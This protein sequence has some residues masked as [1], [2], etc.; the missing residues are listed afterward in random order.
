LRST[1][2]PLEGR[3]LAI[4]DVYDALIS[5]RPYKPPF[6]PKK[7]ATI[8]IAESGTHFDPVLVEVFRKNADKFAEIARSATPP[9]ATAAFLKATVRQP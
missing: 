7:S 1:T 3:L 8:I 9:P 6:S 5:A 4:A 2:I